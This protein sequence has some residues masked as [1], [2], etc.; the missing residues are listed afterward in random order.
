MIYVL[1]QNEKH[2]YL[3]KHRFYYIKLW[4]KEV[5]VTRA[6]YPAVLFVQCMHLSQRG[7]LSVC[8]CLQLLW[9]CIVESD[10]SSKQLFCLFFQ[11]ILHAKFQII[12]DFSGWWVGRLDVLDNMYPNMRWRASCAW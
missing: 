7:T 6:C 9:P 8:T 11:S 2:V 1:E 4:F 12:F 5:I 10:H 3:C